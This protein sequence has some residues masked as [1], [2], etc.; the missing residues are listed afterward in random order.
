MYMKALVLSQAEG[1]KPQQQSPS[2]AAAE[3]QQQHRTI[4]N[5]TWETRG[6]SSTLVA[7]RQYIS[8]RP[9]KEAA[10]HAH[11]TTAAAYTLHSMT[12]LN[13]PLKNT[14]SGAGGGRRGGGQAARR[15]TWAPRR[16]TQCVLGMARPISPSAGYA[17]APTAAGK[18]G[19]E[20]VPP[21]R[22]NPEP[23]GEA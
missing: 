20:I 22:A 1:L 5:P 23:Y 3:L 14:R 12:L 8:T 21:V 16:A 6:R 7:P 9:E 4:T 15:A 17:T 13:A 11:R 2:L 19:K 10:T 18:K